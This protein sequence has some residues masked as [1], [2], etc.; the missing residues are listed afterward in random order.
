MKQS[1]QSWLKQ[2]QDEME[3]T[4]WNLHALAEISWEERHTTAYL[5]EALNGIEVSNRT[6]EGHTG[7]MAEWSGNE[8]PA[9]TVAIRSDIDALWQQVGG[10]WRA[11]HSCG[12]DAHMTMV[13]YALKCLKN[14]GFQPSGKL[15]VLFQPAEETGE[16]ALKLLET[17]ILDQVEYMLGI[18]LRP[19]KEIPL[20]KSSSAIYHGAA[21]VLSGKIT[22]RQAHAAR[23]NEGINVIDSLAAIVHAVNAVKADPTVPSSCKVTRLQ[24]GNTSS[25]IIPDAG[26]FSIDLRA[27]T[28]D[29]MEEL[30]HKV[31]HA[32]LRAG[33]ANG[34][35]VELEP[36]MRT[37]AAVPNEVMERIVASAIT[38]L[39]GESGLAAPPVTPGGED[40]HFYPHRKPGIKATMIGL[41]AD[42]EPGLHHP[43]M[44][45]QLG[46]LQTGAAILAWTIVKLFASGQEN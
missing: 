33:T 46:A 15:I 19:A 43:E 25:N 41:G 45:F 28:N 18:H 36:G 40:F 42:L 11:N 32:V 17:G 16:G 37:A 21:A 30:L 23:P 6:F 27:R 13:F 7:I 8:E 4:Y 31:G 26:E 1:I 22:G 24:V 38:E 10:E 20:G 9:T 3:T 44:R 2:H 12:H 14:I 39:L 5:Q 34:A 29:A 35:E